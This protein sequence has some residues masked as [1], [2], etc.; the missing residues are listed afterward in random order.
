[1]NTKILGWMHER[2][3]LAVKARAL[4]D[5]AEADKRGLSAD[6][7]R[8]YTEY[9]SSMDGLQVKIDREQ[10]LAQR[11]AAM[12]QPMRRAMKPGG[13][14]DAPGNIGMDAKDARRYSLVRA[15]NAMATGNWRGAELEFEASQA[16]AKRLGFEPQGLFVPYDFMEQRDLTKSPTTAGGAMVSTDLLAASFIDL[17]RN[18]M[19]VQQAGA[20][21]LTGLVGDIAIPRQTG[22]ATAYWVAEGNAPAESDQTFDQVTMTPKTV[23]TFTDISR[24]LLKQ[25]SVDVEGLIRSDLSKTL[26]IEIDRAAF[27]GTA[28]NNQ[29]RGIL[30][31][32]GIGAVYAGGA[33]VNGT[34]ANGAAPVWADV[35]NLE[36][37]V[38]ADNADIGSLAYITNAKMRGK[39]KQV[40][41]NATY[42]E[43]PLWLDGPTPINGYRGLVSNQ[44]ASNLSKGGSGAVLS[45]MLF[46]NFADLLIG[47]W[48]GLDLLVDPYT[49]GTSGTVRVIA[50]Q[51]VDVAVRHAE[52][53]AAGIDFVTT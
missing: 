39:L 44:V 42:G 14:G 20:T 53:F 24:K 35:V 23:G 12:D 8:T 37:E 52:S 48:G 45:A 17:L 18:R 2:Q 51:D 4:L 34:N 13:S 19:V 9:L 10:E 15:I 40:W 46:G 1:M 21:V 38:A 7:E 11:E 49:G 47:M 31:T 29:P 26:G 33:T 28:L 43:I 25:S 16:V 6:E 22:G 27:H 41:K 5:T 36:K 32:S 3:A 30:A 50:L